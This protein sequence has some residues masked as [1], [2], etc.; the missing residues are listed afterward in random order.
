MPARSSGRVAGS[1]GTGSTSPFGTTSPIQHLLGQH[2]DEKL[3]VEFQIRAAQGFSPVGCL[4]QQLTG[5]HRHVFGRTEPIRVRRCPVDVSDQ[6][7]IVL[8]ESDAAPDRGP[9]RSPA[10][11]RGAVLLVAALV[12]GAALLTD[13][14][15]DRRTDPTA[16]RPVP[17]GEVVAA[18]LAGDEELVV[19]R[20]T[21][22]DGGQAVAI[23]GAVGGGP[24]RQLSDYLSYDLGCLTGDPVC[25]DVLRTG[26]GLGLFLLRDR[27]DGRTFLLVQAPAGRTVEVGGRAIG[28]ASRGRVVQVP[29]GTPPAVRVTMPDGRWYRLPE[30]P[31]AV[32]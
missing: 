4:G 22:N 27:P 2:L 10:R 15:T 23:W 14:R 12:V 26:G 5:G 29:P 3:G 11:V 18:G 24:F 13:R 7:L 6:N 28:E 19:L 20:R 1:S 25:A 21:P 31:G 8:L 16:V 9:R 32:L 30:M 17:P